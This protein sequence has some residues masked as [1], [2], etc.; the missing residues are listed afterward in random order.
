VIGF[1][2]PVPP[3]T[4][5]TPPISVSATLSTEAAYDFEDATTSVRLDVGPTKVPSEACQIT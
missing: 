3:F 4:F 5:R 2:S 1:T